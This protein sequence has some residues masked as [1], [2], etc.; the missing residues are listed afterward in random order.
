MHTF[1]QVF[2]RWACMVRYPQPSTIQQR[3]LRRSALIQA[4][5]ARVAVRGT[6]DLCPLCYFVPDFS[7]NPVLTLMYIAQWSKVE[8]RL[9]V[10]ALLPMAGLL[11]VMLAGGTPPCITKMGWYAFLCR[12]FLLSV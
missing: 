12:C 2:S 11:C 5:G 7:G 8:L 6:L 10:N 3:T 4:I 1:M 9:S